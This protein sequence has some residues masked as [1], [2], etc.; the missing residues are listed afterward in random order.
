MDHVRG[1]KPVCFCVFVNRLCRPR[2]YSVIFGAFSILCV[3]PVLFHTMSFPTLQLLDCV[4]PRDHLVAFAFSPLFDSRFILDDDV[5][6]RYFRGDQLFD[7]I[8]LFVLECGNYHSCMWAVDTELESSKVGNRLA[9]KRFA[10]ACE[11][12]RCSLG[13]WVSLPMAAAFEHPFA[14]SGNGYKFSRWLTLALG[15]DTPLL[16]V[17]FFLSMAWRLHRVT[18][19][20]ERDVL[21]AFAACRFSKPSKRLATFLATI[22]PT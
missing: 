14:R 1:Q 7:D 19:G 15:E 6:T 5:I 11:V 17:D 8:L 4:N 21:V 22:V 18:D 9:W 16:G 12:Y 13:G 20:Y 10:Y 3:H 2:F